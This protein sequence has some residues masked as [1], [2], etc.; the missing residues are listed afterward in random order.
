MKIVAVP[1]LVSLLGTAR[2]PAL[3]D[4]RLEDDFAASHLPAARN[5][6]VFKMSFLEDVACLGLRTDDPVV[7]YGFGV[8]SHES[9]VA[10][11]KLTQ[12]GFTKVSEFRD[13]LP[14][15][16][17]AGHPV[18]GTGMS[19]ATG[20]LH[21]TMSVDL[22]ESRVEWTGRNLLN[23]HVGSV[24]IRSGQLSFDQRVLVGGEFVLDL[25]AITCADIA[26]SALNRLLLEH[27]QSD[28][29]LDVAQF[30]EARFQIH[31]VELV[32]AAGAGRPNVRIAGELTLR[33][34]VKPLEFLAT[35]GWTPQGRFAAQ[36]VLTFDRTAWGSIYGSGKFFHR[37]GMHLVND[38]IEVQVRLLA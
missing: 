30:P 27:L 33:G 25:N 2:P 31:Q 23:R 28:D 19:P 34:Q 14:A 11:E 13:G 22:G 12:A 1:D 9:R 16:L 4:V 37:L 32:P 18:E 24:A 29:F 36:A 20:S 17:A 35:T 10:A 6:C 8:G 21:G 5:A 15:W 3:L 38:L 26:D 7:V